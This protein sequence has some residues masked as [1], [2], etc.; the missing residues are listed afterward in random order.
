MADMKLTMTRGDTGTFGLEIEGAGQD[1]D[2]A[3]F[4]VR[5]DWQGD[6][7][8]QKTLSDGVSKIDDGQYAIRI[9][10][11]DTQTLDVGEYVYDFQIGANGDVFTLLRGILVIEWD[12]TR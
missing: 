3:F 7:V 11:E 8:F 1:L 10:P 2:T 4:S 6:L 12:V 9:A 5:K